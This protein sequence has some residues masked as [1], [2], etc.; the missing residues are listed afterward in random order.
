MPFCAKCGADV[1]GVRF[2][3][4][5]G[6]PVEEAAGAGASGFSGS[7]S[8]GPQ[9]GASQGS[10]MS[11]N[12]AAALSY[13]TPIAIVFLLIDPYKTI[14]FVRFHSFQSIFFCV[15]A[16]ILQVGLTILSI[17]LGFAGIGLLMGL[18]SPF[19]SLAIFVLWIVLVIKAYQGQMF[20]L[21]VIGDLARKQL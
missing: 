14:R 21:P 8:A 6:A 19:I 12:V 9:V 7:A 15:A 13:I 10:G 5:C 2:C 18:L 20:D 17:V 1:T 16:I 3:A 11:E 4:K